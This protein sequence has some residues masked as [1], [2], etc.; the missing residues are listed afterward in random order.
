M[1]KLRKYLFFRKLR[2]CQKHSHRELSQ[3]GFTLLELVAVVTLISIL[4][5]ILVPSWLQFIDTQRVIS[6]QAVVH[7]GM[8]QAQ[9][10][11]Q[12]NHA[13]WQFSIQDVNGTV[14]WSV[15]ST[16]ATL[17][18]HTWQSVGHKSVQIDPETTLQPFGSG[19]TVRFDHKGNVASRLG[20]VTLSSQRFSQVKRCVYVS[21]IIGA[22][23][24][25]KEQSK[26]S[27]GDF[28][29]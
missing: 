18:A 28:C 5:A 20:R 4:M 1:K 19:R 21:T 22:L 8:Q 25:S 9:N 7:Q 3:S 17:G 10:K 29:Y 26:A 6:A 2:S 27:D 16:A 24:E 15:H 11:A 13:E 14:E 23:R 12:Q